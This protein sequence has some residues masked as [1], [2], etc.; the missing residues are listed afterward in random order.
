[1]RNVLLCRAIAQ[2]GE[3]PQAEGFGR[4]NVTTCLL[5]GFRLRFIYIYLFLNFVVD[6]LR[7]ENR[8][9]LTVVRK[10]QAE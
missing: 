8:P 5:C 1:M 9:P 6:R 4:I 2:M 3:V 7:K 10:G